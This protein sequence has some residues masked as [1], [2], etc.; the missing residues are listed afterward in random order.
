[1]IRKGKIAEKGGEITHVFH[2]P[3]EKARERQ[4]ISRRKKKGG[5]KKGR[6]PRPLIP[7]PN[8]GQGG[9][10]NTTLLSSKLCRKTTYT[11]SLQEGTKKRGRERGVKKKVDLIRSLPLERPRGGGKKKFHDLDVFYYYVRPPRLGGGGRG[12]KDRVLSPS[13][14]EKGKLAVL[15]RFQ[16]KSLA[17]SRRFPGGVRERLTICLYVGG[18]GKKGSNLRWE[19][20]PPNS[21]RTYAREKKRTL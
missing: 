18:G 10:E 7:A 16:P 5:E 11:L 20:R 4:R 13:R 19:N 9:K 14:R 21:L 3:T 12:G 2:P 17:T 6:K 1:V 15:L 8:Q